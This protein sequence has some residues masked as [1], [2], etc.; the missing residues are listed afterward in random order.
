M[1]MS[2]DEDEHNRLLSLTASLACQVPDYCL[3]LLSR[4]HSTK[5]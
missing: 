2:F 4:H 1:M 3:W 5:K